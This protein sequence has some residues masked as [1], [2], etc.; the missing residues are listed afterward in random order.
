MS[1]LCGVPRFTRQ[2][3][4]LATFASAFG[5]DALGAGEPGG[6]DAGRLGP[7]DGPPVGVPPPSPRVRKTAA[8]PAPASASRTTTMITAIVVP[9]SPERP[10]RA[11]GCCGPHTSPVIDP[12]A[13]PGL[14]PYAP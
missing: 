9:D 4:V 7:P 6:A 3:P 11:G 14:P 2:S 10:G 1:G 13:W 8:A 12:G 5:V